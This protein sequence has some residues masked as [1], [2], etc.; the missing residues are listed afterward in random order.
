MSE[1]SRTNPRSRLGAWISIRAQAGW[2]PLRFSLS[3]AFGDLPEGWASARHGARLWTGLVGLAC[4]APFIALIVAAAFQTVG[5]N[6]LYQL[7]SSSSPAILAG[8]VSLFIGIPIA[9]AI[10][11]WR[12]TRVG[13]RQEGGSIDGLMA[14]EYAPLHLVVVFTALVFG[15][16]FVGHL[17]ADS[18]ACFNGVKTAC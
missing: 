12:I 18:L 10:N 1:F 14:F 8:T 6:Q 9:I 7:I 4:I 2:K 16:L 11:L 15:G 5:L 17:A 3:F 13:L